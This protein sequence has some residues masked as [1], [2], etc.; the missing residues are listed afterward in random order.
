MM[1][2][3]SESRAWSPLRWVVVIAVLY[4]GQMAL[5]FVLGRQ[6][7]AVAPPTM[8]AL[9]V[10]IPSYRYV[11]IPGVDRP[12]LLV[13]EN[14]AGFS[15]LFPESEK[16]GRAAGWSAQPDGVLSRPVTPPGGDLTNIPKNGFS[17]AKSV[18]DRPKPS[19][20]SVV[21]TDETIAASSFVVEGELASRRLLPNRRQADPVSA[22][23]LSNTVVQIHVDAQGRVFDLPVILFPADKS[24][25]AVADAEAIATARAL[26]FAPATG[27]SGSGTSGRQDDLTRGTVVFQWRTVP[28]PATNAASS[29]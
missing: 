29:P 11:N 23:A 1:T 16:S 24:G 21:V 10:H 27:G 19:M 8:P 6:R 17:T 22:T 26:K 7:V 14:P 4:G 18:V 12:T 28:P 25:S 3:A 20:D 9:A 5:F 15:K 2:T 13:T